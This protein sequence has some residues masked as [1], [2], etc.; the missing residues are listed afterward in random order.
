MTPEVV[1]HGL[2]A[3]YKFMFEY[4]PFRSGL[5]ASL[6]DIPEDAKNIQLTPDEALA[7]GIREIQSNPDNVIHFKAPYASWQNGGEGFNFTRDMHPSAMAHWE[8][9][10][11]DVHGEQIVKEIKNF[12]KRSVNQ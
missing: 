5:M 1:N 6:I 4:I 12:V 3:W 9:V 8:Q 2:V 7:A 11:A 10:A